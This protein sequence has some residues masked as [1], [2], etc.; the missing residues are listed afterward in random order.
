MKYFFNTQIG[1]MRYRLS[2]GSLLCKDVPIARTGEQRYSADDLPDIEPDENGL[3]IVERTADEV[4]SEETMAS[5]EGMSITIDHPSDISG[6]IV[7]VDPDNWRELAFGHC[8]NVRRGNDKNADLLLADLVVKDAEAIKAIDDGLRQISCGYDAHYEQLSPGRARQSLIT[9]NHVALVN[10]G[11]A[12]LRC[13]IGDKDTMQLKKKPGFLALFARAVKT[14]DADDIAELVSASGDSEIPPNYALAPQMP[15]QETPTMD[16]DRPE[17]V[18]ELLS[19]IQSLAPKT[20]DSDDEE[21]DKDKAG[22]SEDDEDKEMS[23]DSDEEKESKVTGDTAY[24]AELITPGV[25]LPAKVKNTDFKRSVLAA[26]DKQLVRMVVGDSDIKKLPKLAVDMAFNA[27]SELA[28]T[29]NTKSRT[30][31]RALPT[32][33]SIQSINERNRAFWNK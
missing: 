20:T 11:R 29:R 9:G 4:F 18:D 26:A 13:A 32:D 19:A 8:Q 21:D 10:K 17:W 25:E 15:E 33:N 2:D 12:G 22:D 5:F 7:F 24:R 28:K 16:S 6:D 27:V 14:G 30:T 31:D 1:D 23:G 3:I